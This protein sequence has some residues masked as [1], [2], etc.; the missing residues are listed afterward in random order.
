MVVTKLED[1]RLYVIIDYTGNEFLMKKIK[2][3]FKNA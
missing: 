2:L 1:D 3:E